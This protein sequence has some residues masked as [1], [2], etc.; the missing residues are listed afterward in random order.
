MD[1]RTQLPESDLMGRLLANREWQALTANGRTASIRRLACGRLFV[2][3][4]AGNGALLQAFAAHKLEEAMRFFYDQLE[5][6]A[7]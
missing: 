4:N 1:A 2:R 6:T 3:Y 5:A 7:P